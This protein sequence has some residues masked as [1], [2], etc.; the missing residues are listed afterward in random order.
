MMI[1]ETLALT[2]DKRQSAGR[3]ATSPS[4]GVIWHP[5]QSRIGNIAPLFYGKTG[6]A[7]L[8]RSGL[9]FY[10]DA[11]NEGKPLLDRHISRSPLLI[12][13]IT[14]TEYEIV[15]PTSKMVVSVNGRVVSDSVTV[16]L[17]DMGREIIISLSDKVVLAIFE[18]P[19]QRELSSKNHG[20][21]GI[22]PQIQDVWKVIEQAGPTDLPVLIK[23]ATG[24]GK[25]LIAQA[26]HAL[27]R[28][29]GHVML[30]VNM[31][32]ISRELAAADLFGTARGAF[33]GAVQDKTGL[34]E[35]ASK[36]TLFLDEIGD[37]PRIVQPMLLRALETGE[38]R[39]VGETR[40]KKTTPR[41][42]A[43]TDRALTADNFSQP[44]LRR[45]ESIIVTALNL[46]EHRV[47]IGILIK[48]FM[49]GNNTVQT[50]PAQASFSG[51][52]VARL[53]LHD[54]P[55]NVRELRN[56]V[57]QVS[58]GQTPEVLLNHHI[59]S[60]SRTL[61]QGAQAFRKRPQYRPPTSVSED[62]MLKALDRNQW[63]IKH[64][65][66]MLNV[67][68]T[69]LYSLMEKSKRVRRSEELSELEIKQVMARKPNDIDFWAKE[70]RV[71]RDALKRRVKRLS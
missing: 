63:C 31:A 21:L 51:S 9:L 15:P 48:H 1:D 24:T 11:G 16:S 6:T 58:I 7:E 12:R 2:L 70:L 10:D 66:S 35:Q 41:I 27:S 46:R 14:E 65:A 25:E 30:N 45:L 52:S 29:S 26:L 32:T 13:R 17:K 55:G 28:R 42:V 5:D 38:I 64:A 36:G 4:I 44:L 22:S 40:V 8:S 54:W 20:L 3:R 67:S 57:Q 43:A 47:D 59:D 34:F 61:S 19:S 53:A 18:C 49:G 50:R 56:I 37:T 60:H 23:G 33:T 69:A 62:E 71:P 68:R 39:R